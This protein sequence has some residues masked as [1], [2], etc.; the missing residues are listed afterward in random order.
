VLVEG[1]DHVMVVPRAI[2]ENDN[3]PIV[4]H[5]LNR[6]YDGQKDAVV[7]QRDFTLRLRRDLL[8]GRNLTSATLHAPKRETVKLTV[9]SDDGCTTVQVP[10]L[11]L[12]ALLELGE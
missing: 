12:W 1:S 4:V 8:D 7:P 2:P 3:T 9:T 10:D 6:Q 5:L 11:S